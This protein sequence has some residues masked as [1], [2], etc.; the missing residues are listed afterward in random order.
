MLNGGEDQIVSS[1]LYMSVRR[2]IMDAFC[3]RKLNKFRRCYHKCIKMFFG[4]SKYHSVTAVLVD[5][6]LPS[7]N[8]IMQYAQSSSY[9][10][11]TLVVVWQYADN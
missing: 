5:L 4:Y 1:L 3:C 7:F 2:R 6:K 8:A 10:Q 9:I 11:C